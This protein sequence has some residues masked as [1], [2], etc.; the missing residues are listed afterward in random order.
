MGEQSTRKAATFM[1]TVPQKTKRNSAFADLCR[2]SCCVIQ[3]CTNG[4]SLK[5]LTRAI[6]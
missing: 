3:L 2:R 4:Y 5:H 1:M 6:G